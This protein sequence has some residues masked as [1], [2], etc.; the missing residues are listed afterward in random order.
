MTS[1]TYRRQSGR[2]PD[3]LVLFVVVLLDLEHLTIF[4]LVR[5]DIKHLGSRS[6]P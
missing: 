5:T 4:M 2:S 3:I 6:D 1:L